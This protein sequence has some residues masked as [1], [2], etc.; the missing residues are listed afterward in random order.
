MFYSNM[1]KINVDPSLPI[2]TSSI[3][4]TSTSTSA[5]SKEPRRNCKTCRQRMS[6]QKFDAHTVCINCRDIV[7]DLANRCPECRDWSLEQFQLYLKHRKSLDT[8]SGKKKVVVKSSSKQ[9]TGDRPVTS[10][11][12]AEFQSKMNEMLEQFMQ[13]FQSSQV[14]QKSV[15]NVSLAAPVHAPEPAPPGPG[16]ERALSDVIDRELSVPIQGG[17]VDVRRDLP[18]IPRSEHI[19]IVTH[20]AR[21]V[22]VPV[23]KTDVEIWPGGGSGDSHDSLTDS[24]SGF[25]TPGQGK[26]DSK[27]HVPTDGTSVDNLIDLPTPSTFTPSQLLFPLRQP[28]HSDPSVPPVSTVPIYS[29]SPSSSLSLPSSVFSSVPSSPSFPS[30]SSSKFSEVHCN[31]ELAEFNADRLNLS[32]DYRESV[33][34]FYRKKDPRLRLFIQKVRPD[35]I[36]DYERDH[37]LGESVYMGSLR[38]HSD[39]PV[40]SGYANVRSSEICHTVSAADSVL[41]AT[42]MSIVPPRTNPLEFH[43]GPISS[44]PPYTELPSHTHASVVASP[45]IY[46]PPA[47]TL[48][49]VRYSTDAHTHQL[50]SPLLP[51]SHQQLRYPPPTHAPSYPYHPPLT[52]SPPF[53]PPSLSLTQPSSPFVPHSS[54][55]PAHFHVPPFTCSSTQQYS[56]TPHTITC[57]QSTASSHDYNLS[58]RTVPL[59]SGIVDVPSY[60]PP[61][62]SYVPVLPRS[63]PMVVTSSTSVLDSFN[64]WMK[65]QEA[66]R[67]FTNTT[68]TTHNTD[69]VGLPP[70]PTGVNVPRPAPHYIPVTVQVGSTPYRPFPE[71]PACPRDPEEERPP[72][73]NIPDPENPVLMKDYPRMLAYLSSMFPNSKGDNSSSKRKRSAFE[74]FWQPEEPPSS[75][76][77]NLTWSERVAE[78]LEETDQNLINHVSKGKQDRF[79]LPKRK[80]IYRVSGDTAD[81]EAAA[82]NVSVSDLYQYIPKT[83]RQVGMTVAEVAALESTLRYQLEVM[84][85]SMWVM[86]GLMG[87]IRSEGF[88]PK[89]PNL[90]NS[91]VNSLSMG[92][93]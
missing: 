9:D 55:L 8:K 30:S 19:N 4:T 39:F 62:T 84:S 21:D 47:R 56:L 42:G 70:W 48:G 79:L 49:N 38:I 46:A 25:I 85:H 75:P 71:D 91:F 23:K 1:E 3:V 2:T 64:I 35:L 65:N 53:L 24:L 69:S 60:R 81:G 40:H 44:A 57:S 32:R 73:Q 11:E 76:Y 41:S 14:T 50:P 59:R 52:R 37:Q 77:H 74:Q 10:S 15:T 51:H 87:M 83:N 6:L 16:S 17:G 27:C 78:I 12:L 31:I 26:L 20:L 67:T 28:S 68:P 13:N 33:L 5:P 45:S 92:L 34:M 61:V 66:V 86:T 54:E 58:S 82:L 80:N 63:S 36:S 93:A 29:V 18:P 88:A 7:C 90:F 72:D 89:D 43:Y 22:H